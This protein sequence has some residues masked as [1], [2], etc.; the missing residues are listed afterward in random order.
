LPG[1]EDAGASDERD[2][3]SSR[4][5]ALMMQELNHRSKNILQSISATL[6]LIAAKSENHEARQALYGAMQRLSVMSQAYAMLYRT[7]NGDTV[8]F[9]DYLR[10]LCGALAE[11]LNAEPER[12]QFAVEGDNPRW[13]QDSVAELGF[14]VCETVM[15]A[16]KHAF[17][18]TGKGHITL[19]LDCRPQQC[20]LE[21]GDDGIGFD[22]STVIEGLG[23]KLIE[24][25]AR[26][27]S[28]TVE[29]ISA[30]G[31]GTRVRIVF[32]PPA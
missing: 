22:R 15:N 20:A 17:P 30:P 3:A 11:A 24:A 6:S 32:P 27:L 19:H 10:E 23:A 2:D 25:F 5:R 7:G 8:P 28:G 1:I 13:P 16:I 18:M 14:L 21:I 26:R 12:M 29:T 4:Q 9:G 31:G